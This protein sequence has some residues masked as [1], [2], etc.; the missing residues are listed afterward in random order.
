[1]KTY[2]CKVNLNGSRNN[3]V[4]KRGVTAAEIAILREIHGKSPNGAAPITDIKPAG[5]VKRTDTVERARLASRYSFGEMKGPKLVKEVLGVDGVPLPQYVPGVDEPVEVEAEETQAAEVA[6][7][8][9]P[10]RTRVAPKVETEEAAT[11][12]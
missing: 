11:A 12:A 5:E 2:D 10:K 8:P 9:K 3:A 7:T 6:P 4:R 1:M